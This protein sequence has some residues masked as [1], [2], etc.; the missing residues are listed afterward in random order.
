MKIYQD[1]FSG[2]EVISDSYKMEEIYDGV[3]I[4]VKGR[5]VVKGEAN[6]D[7]GCG[8]AFGGAEEEEGA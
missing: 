4:E 6:V 3:A 2:E 8:N 7:I 1:I 5:M